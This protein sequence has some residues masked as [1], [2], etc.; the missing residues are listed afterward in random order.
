MY[1]EK[2]SPSCD[3]L[4]KRT[5][6]GYPDLTQRNLSNNNLMKQL[7]LYDEKV[8]QSMNL[9]GDFIN[10]FQENIYGKKCLSKK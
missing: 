5:K 2:L 7:G 8:T 9:S 4:Q 3:Y 1:S 6:I 10:K